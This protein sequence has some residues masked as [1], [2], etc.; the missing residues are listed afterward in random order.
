MA[1]P[2]PLSE[3]PLDAAHP[4]SYP[5]YHWRRWG[6]NFLTI[7]ILAHL[8]L[9]L[10]ATYLVVQNIEAKRRRTFTAPSPG[11]HAPTQALEHKVQME[12]KQQTMSAP[13]ALKRITTT[14]NSKVSL[15]SLPAMPNLDSLTV[16]TAMAGM[17][18]SGVGLSAG[19]GGGSGGG[20]GGGLSL[21]GFHGTAGSGLQGVFYDYKMDQ[22]YQ[23]IPSFSNA[24][25]GKMVR[26]M[27][28]VNGPWHPEEPY[29]HFRSAA[30][31]HSR[32]FIFPAIK[33]TEAGAAFQSPRSG[34]GHWL[35]IYRGTFSAS[36]SGSFR[37]VGFGDNVMIVQ[38]GKH[39]V[40]DA[41]D[42]GYTG[43]ARERLGNVAFP[44]KGATPLYAGEWFS[45][46][47]GEPSD[48]SIAVG[49]EGGIF[50]SG[51]FIQARNSAYEVGEHGIPKLPVFMLGAPN[52]ADKALLGKYLPPVCLQ[53]P[54]FQVGG[55]NPDESDIFSH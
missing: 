27:L 10:G 30:I 52:A 32:Y 46:R 17:G 8:L 15:P 48:I 41:S 50:C 55:V 42:H 29:K 7:S 54:Y 36:S 33:D 23:P 43:Q 18:G 14:S 38:I 9:T 25:F 40:L 37:F 47:S 19:G 51:L 28:P 1:S 13:A 20:N 2:L 24:T 53:G 6:F 16:P 11:A 34:P 22:A 3:H 49:D 26:D 35:A 12:K 44:Q 39:N 31:L 4:P 5:W 21:F 45:L